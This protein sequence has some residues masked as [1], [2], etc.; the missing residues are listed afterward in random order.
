[1]MDIVN[2]PVMKAKCKTCPFHT[3]EHGRHLDP[4]LVSIIQ[5]D[6][7]SK[8]SQ[9]CHHPRLIGEKETHICRGARDFQIEIFYRL[10]VLETPTQEA[11]D[12][13]LNTVEG[14]R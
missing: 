2:L 3:D 4:H 12:K 11:W 13:A 7:I 9:L 1:M 14:N 10:G 5:A 6:I 8:A